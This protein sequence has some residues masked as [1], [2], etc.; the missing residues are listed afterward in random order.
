MSNEPMHEHKNM[1]PWKLGSKNGE[2]REDAVA[3]LVVVAAM[4]MVVA[5]KDNV[6]IS[7]TTVQDAVV[8]VK[9]ARRSTRHLA[10]LLTFD[11]NRLLTRGTRICRM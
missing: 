4:A 9:V 1:V 3:V 10:Y 11:P 7:L 5:D 8:V 6:G 2:T